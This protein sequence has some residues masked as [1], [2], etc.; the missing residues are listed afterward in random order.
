MSHLPVAASTFP[1][2]YSMTGLDALGHLRGMGYSDFELMI[3][4]PHCWPSLLTA[5]QRR[6]YRTWLDGEGARITSLCYPLIDNNPNSP[7]PHM[8]QYTLDRYYEA[9]D[10]AA[11]LAC[12]YVVMIPGVHGG[13]IDPPKAW[14]D[15]WFVESVRKV[16]DH[17][18]AAGVRILLENVPFTHRPS[19]QDMKELCDKIGDVGVNFDTCNSAYIKEDVGDAIRMLG[20][21]IEN[22]HISDTP[23]DVFRHDRLGTGI[24][25]PAPIMAALRDIGYDKLTVLEIIADANL[26]GSDPDGDIRAS[27]DILARHGWAPL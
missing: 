24:V 6:A 7:D 15:D 12:P 26:P 18:K 14:L 11:E 5:D 16:N 22:V 23:A 10:F 3:F 13:L 17:A 25:D 1:Y 27:H 19:A 4:P 9:I 8:R 21:L 2:L 20:D